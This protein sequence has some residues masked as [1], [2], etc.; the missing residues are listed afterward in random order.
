[1]LLRWR[2]TLAPWLFVC[3]LASAAVVLTSI[4]AIAMPQLAQRFVLPF[5]PIPP[6]TTTRLALQPSSAS[7]VENE[8]LR[9]SVS[10]ERL[11]RGGVTLAYT[12]PNGSWTSVPMTRRAA[13]TFEAVIG[14]VTNDVRYY[15]RGG[16]ARTPIATARV[17]RKPVMTATRV[18][19]TYPPHTNRAPLTIANTDGLIEAPVGTQADVTVVASV[20]LSSAAI[21]VGGQKIDLS[22]GDNPSER[23]G[24]LAVSKDERWALAMT[25]ADHVPGAGPPSL[26]IRAIPD[27]PPMVQVL[28]PPGELRLHPRDILSLPFQALDDYGVTSLQTNVQITASGVDASGEPL[29]LAQG[30]PATQPTTWGGADAARAVDGNTDGNFLAGSVSHTDVPSAWW[31]VDLGNVAPVSVIEVWNRADAAPERLSDFFVFVSDAPFLSDDPAAITA[32]AGVATHRIAGQ[33]GRPARVEVF[34]TARFVRVQLAKA[35]YLS[36]AEVRVLQA[37]PAAAGELA[38]R[39][40]NTNIAVSGD[41]RQQEG[42]AFLDLAKIKVGVGD[43]IS[44]SVTATDT[45][46]QVATGGPIRVVVS[47]RSIDQRTYDR[48]GELRRASQRAT[49]LVS[50]LDAAAGS[51]APAGSRGVGHVDAY[52]AALAAASRELANVSETTGALQS[53]LLRCIIRSDGP[54]LSVALAAMVDDVQQVAASASAIS[55][56]FAFDSTPTDADRAAFATTVASARRVADHI[57]AILRGEQAGAILADLDNLRASELGTPSGKDAA[58]RARERARRVREDIVAAAE[59]LGLAPDAADVE[60]SLKAMTT[61]RADVIKSYA[62]RDYVPASQEYAGALL[63]GLASRSSL[64]PRLSA[65]AQAEAVRPDANLVR[66]RDLQLAASAALR[67]REAPVATR[68]EFAKL[69]AAAIAALQAEHAAVQVIATAVTPLTTPPVPATAPTSA[70]ATSATAT[71]VTMVAATLPATT[72]TL[73][74]ATTAT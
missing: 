55:S 70:P 73:A 48:I 19:Y 35:E 44:V 23:R 15:A 27:R 7:V 28:Q 13:E 63:A 74:A 54:A 58:D 4:P 52:L 56:R 3:L 34:R 12:R 24:T 61:A 29:N 31:Q 50:Q 2:P 11:T 25:S 46:K 26:A 14:P 21:E 42:E 57:A 43:V 41:A 66:A 71:T 72:A 65:A 62:V 69:F 68:E 8:S 45:G 60:T 39:S 20:P 36:L 53:A 64:V 67:A 37:K 40:F 49:A 59:E 17:L 18:R 22:P 9:V 30:K 10:A 6:A 47:P 16:D 5:R 1:R 38:S 51:F 33:C 32:Q